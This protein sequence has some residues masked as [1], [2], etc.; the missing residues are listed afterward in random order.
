MDIDRKQIEKYNIIYIQAPSL[1]GKNKSGWTVLSQLI[2]HDISDIIKTPEKKS[3]G[4]IGPASHVLFIS[5]YMGGNR[6]HV[7]A[8]LGKITDKSTIDEVLLNQSRYPFFRRKMFLVQS[9]F[10][11][12]V[13]KF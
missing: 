3:T 11:L 1:S 4:A 5:K 12:F 10:S 8:V 13:I 6:N 7:A 9:T 2:P